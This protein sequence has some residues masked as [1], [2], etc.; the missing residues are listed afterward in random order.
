MRIGRTRVQAAQLHLRPE[1]VPDTLDHV[2]QY[3]RAAKHLALVH[4]VGQPLGVRFSPELHPGEIAFAVEDL[5]DPFPQ[6][7][8]QIGAHT[9]LEDDEPLLVEVPPL[10]AGHARLA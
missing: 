6:L 3:D 1:Y 10:V 4:Q 8:E 2:R 9:V 7:T 5:V